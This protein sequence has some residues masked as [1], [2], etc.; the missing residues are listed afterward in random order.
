GWVLSVFIISYG[1][2]QVPLGVWGD[3]RGHRTVLALIVL[4]WS[5]FTG[6]TGM[7]GGFVS[8]LVIRFL[9]GIGEAGSYPCMTGVIG[10]WYQKSETS[11]AQGY[12]WAASRMGGALTPFVVIPVIAFFGW[13]TAFYMLAALGVV[14]AVAWYF[15]Y[16]DNPR[17]MKG[18]S[19]A[20]LGK[21]P[22]PSDRKT[23]R[24]PWKAI[25]RGRQFWLILVMYW[26]YAWGSW[27]FFSWFPT[28]MEKGRGFAQAELTYAVAVPFILSMIGNI[29]G[30]YLSARWSKKYGLKIGRKLLGVGGLAVSAIFMFLAAFIPGKMQVFIFLSL[31]FGVID[32]MLPSAWAIC[33]DVGKRYAGAISGAM[34]TAGNIG[35]FVCA[36]VFGYIVSSTGNYN[37]P[38]FVIAGMLIIS[39]ILFLGI[40]PT[41]PLVADEEAEAAEAK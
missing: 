23:L 8:L 9:F 4:W 13:R 40:D 24:I 10:R 39:A 27:F 41:K 16:R 1:L 18:I 7:A 26:F 5:V 19:Q 36:T 29:S 15:W 3:R 14:W 12:I 28:F 2:L 30:G 11:I 6:F 20:E 31:C 37:Y 17:Q 34:N 38:L 33:I 35:G 22:E 21:L 25:M 32:L